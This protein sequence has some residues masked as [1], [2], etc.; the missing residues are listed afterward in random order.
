MNLEKLTETDLETVTK[1][2]GRRPRSALHIAARCP[3]G[4]PAVITNHPLHIKANRIA[5]FPTM[6]WLSC[7]E[8]GRIIS[9]LEMS[10]LIQ[11]L[12]DR[13]AQDDE[14][15]AALQSDHE[16]YVVQR[17]QLLNETEQLQ[18]RDAGLYDMFQKR[19]IGGL[20]HWRSVKCL[21][22]HFAHHL[23]DSNAIGAILSEE[24]GVQPCGC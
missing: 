16:R 9:R 14:L 20:N 10:G 3:E 11:Q 12:D 22:L 5:P 6:F 19:G 13:L 1:Q 2:L 8:L 24:F 21:H 15:A 17:W 18:V 7:P 23:A 4:H